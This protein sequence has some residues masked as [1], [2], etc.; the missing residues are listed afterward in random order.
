MK[1]CDGEPMLPIC[2]KKH[3]KD[4][5]NGSQNGAKIHLIIEKRRSQKR[6]KNEEQDNRLKAEMFFL[7]FVFLL[8]DTDAREIQSC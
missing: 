7:F 5:R 1:K 8:F 3:Q 2:F 6:I 4:T